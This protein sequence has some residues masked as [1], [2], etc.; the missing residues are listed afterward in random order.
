MTLPLKFVPLAYKVWDKAMFSKAS[1]ILSTEGGGV[2]PSHNAMGLWYIQGVNIESEW[3]EYWGEYGGGK[4]EGGEYGAVASR[5]LN[6]MGEIWR[7][8]YRG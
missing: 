2:H 1:V 7:G 8:E 5:G 6:R 3:G 4:Y